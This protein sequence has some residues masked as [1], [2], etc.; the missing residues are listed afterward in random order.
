MVRRVVRVVG[1][2]GFR[3]FGNFIGLLRLVFNVWTPKRTPKAE[4][5][6]G[7]Q[8]LKTSQSTVSENL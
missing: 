7:V 2:V 6:F 1:F 8:T 4:F 5:H 3:R